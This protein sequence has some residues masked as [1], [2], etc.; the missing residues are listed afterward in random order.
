MENEQL[1]IMP[2]AAHHSMI[3]GQPAPFGFATRTE[4]Q[5]FC[6]EHRAEGEKVLVTPMQD[7]R[8]RPT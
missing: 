7:R 2:K 1:A 8:S 3:C 5:Y 6:L 4:P